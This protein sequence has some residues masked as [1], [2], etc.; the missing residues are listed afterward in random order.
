[1]KLD[2]GE[3]KGRGRPYLDPGHGREVG[4]LIRMTTALKERIRA[5]AQKEGV[6]MS[7]YM[8]RLA[9]S[10]LGAEL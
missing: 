7:E 3:C 8:R 4:L 10:D 1:M 5:A 2:K 9:E 6:G